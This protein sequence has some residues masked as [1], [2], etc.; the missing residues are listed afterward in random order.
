MDT[1]KNHENY[2]LDPETLDISEVLKVKLSNWEVEYD[3]TL[4][5]DNPINS[6]FKTPIQAQEFH[7]TGLQ[8]WEQL[9]KE[10]PLVQFFYS[11]N[12]KN[13]NFID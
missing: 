3:N 9:Q 13:Q 8:L 7:K 12:T 5:Q 4:D 2:N 1:A 11:D 10:M 6:G